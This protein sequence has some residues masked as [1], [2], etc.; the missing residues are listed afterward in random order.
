MRK[1]TQ[2]AFKLTN[3]VRCG[4]VVSLYFK[5]YSQAIQNLQTLEILLPLKFKNIFQTL[6]NS[7]KK[8][9]QLLQMRC[10]LHNHGQYIG[11]EYP[12][13]DSLIGASSSNNCRISHIPRDVFHYCA[14]CIQKDKLNIDCGR[15][16]AI[17]RICNYFCFCSF[18]ICRV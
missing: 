5:C 4:I 13:G 12:W 18:G 7:T 6:S 16:C 17:S 2:K 1:K 8:N 10:K 14:G 15:I 9:E 11:L 3:A